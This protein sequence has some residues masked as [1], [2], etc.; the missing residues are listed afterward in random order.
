M[1]TVLF[2]TFSTKYRN[3]DRLDGVYRYIREQRLNWRVQ[4]V[5]YGNSKPKIEDIVDLLIV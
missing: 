1:K 5:E 3:K 4:V 2:F